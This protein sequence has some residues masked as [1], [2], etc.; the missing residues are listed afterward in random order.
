[1]PLTQIRTS[2]L[3]T[4][5]SLFFRNRIINGDM[6]I[7]QRNAGASVSLASS[8][9]ATDRFAWHDSNEAGKA[10]GTLQQVSDAPANFSYSLRLTTTTAKTSTGVAN[11]A[12]F[13]PY[14]EG[15]NVADF[16]W[17]TA[18]AR[19]VTLSFWVKA[20]AT[21]T[22]PVAFV[23][24]TEDR[25][26]V[27]TYTVNAIST[28]E[29]KTITIPGDTSGTWDKTSGI[30]IRLTFDMGS[31]S[32][33][34]APTANTWATGWYFSVAGVNKPVSVL[35]STWQITGVQ[36]EIGTAATAFE[37]RPITTELQLCQRY[38]YKTYN[39][40]V[41]VGTSTS[42]GSIYCE[43][44]ADG[45]LARLKPFNPRLPVSMRAT[46]SVTLYTQT[47][48]AGAINVYSNSASTLTVS[49][50]QNHG[51][52]SLFSYIQTS[53]NGVAAQTYE[54]HATASAEIA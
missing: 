24:Q 21:G 48:T 20:S 54:L 5:N 22:Y 32:N 10:V 23:N 42:V 49:S 36:L 39:T 3:D 15:Y 17:G 29:Y 34:V 43:T 30:G 45:T 41:A 12:Q 4:T 16:N 1:M 52:N 35:N 25:S 28:W 18:N 19:S 27:T 51:T 26:Y 8:A 7:D 46:P 2:N 50:V 38:F 11:R 31:G 33:Y 40:E 9:Y 47:G 37:T 13:R 6:R 53:T 44:L 14:P